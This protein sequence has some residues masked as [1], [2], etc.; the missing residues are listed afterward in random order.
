MILQQFLKLSYQKLHKYKFVKEKRKYIWN[1]N[2]NE[3]IEI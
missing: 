2:E 1:R 3:C